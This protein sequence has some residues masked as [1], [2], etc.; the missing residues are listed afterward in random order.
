ML[1]RTPVAEGYDVS[2]E[3]DGGTALAWVERSLPDLIVLDVKMPGLD[4]LA[5]TRRLRAKRLPVPIVLP[6]VK[7]ALAQ[8]VAGFDA[9]AYG[10][11]VITG[12]GKRCRC[13]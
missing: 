4:G 8:R 10:V 3:P 13:R 11:V 1:E 6:G 2:V 5:V 7:D 12:L 9:A